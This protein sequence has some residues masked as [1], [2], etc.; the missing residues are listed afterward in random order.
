MYLIGRQ[1][2]ILRYLKNKDT[3]VK[4][5]ELAK[6]FGVTDR[7]IRNDISAIKDVYGENIIDA[8]RTKGYKYNSEVDIHNTFFYDIDITDSG[9]RIIYILKK[10]ILNPEPVNIFDLS[11]ELSIS[12]RSIETDIQRLKKIFNT[13]S[14]DSVYI[15][16]FEDNIILSGYENISNNLIY[17]IIK[18]T[19][20]NLESSEYQKFFTNINIDYLKGFII[21]ILN[22]FKYESRYLSLSR[23]LL[24]ISLIIECNYI[25]GE[26]YGKKYKEFIEKYVDEIQGKYTNMALKISTMLYQH[27]GLN[28]SQYDINYIAYILY[29]KGKMEII[30]DEIRNEN[31]VKDDF[32]YFCVNILNK[33]KNEKGIEFIENDNLTINFIYHLKIAMKRIELGI[34]L[35][36]P[37]ADKLTKEYTYVIDLAVMV[38]DMIYEEYDIKFDFNEISYIGIY[39]ATAIHNVY[40][41]QKNSDRFKILLYIP[42]G[43]GN[44]N[45]IHHQ[46][47]KLINKS[48]IIIDGTTNI[49]MIIEALLEYDLIITTSNRLNMENNKIHIINKRFDSIEREKIKDIINNEIKLFEQYKIKKICSIFFN[50]NIFM[51][52]IDAKDKYEVIEYMSNV[53]KENGYVDENFK[54]YVIEREKIV[55]TEIETG[56]ALPH[57][58]KN[59]AYRN[60]MAIAF[61]KNSI[62]WDNYKV[63]IVFMYANNENYLEYSNIFTLSFVDAVSDPKFIEDIKS[64]KN[65]DSFIKLFTEY[66]IKNH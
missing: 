1:V 37:L 11:E 62:V 8:I 51:Y 29:I 10:L 52:N 35:Y 32:Y 30:E 61:L 27:F 28:V 9:N 12:E 56:I 43:I 54:N 2:K 14:L 17:D 50:E 39:L 55:P 44:L 4:G 25:Y 20:E 64:C 48:K 36:N 16:R 23:F 38:A 26:S 24:D 63:K 58:I 3:F 40:D 49:N 45:L 13:L 7:T 33:L 18:Y 19:N 34:K 41:K 42:E 22:D 21:G 47:E 15:K 59:T 6:V 65:L 66:Y 53:L 60:G 46:I 5:S 31:I 57:S